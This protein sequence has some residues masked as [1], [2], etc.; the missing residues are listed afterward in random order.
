MWES[1]ICP[2]PATFEFK[3]YSTINYTFVSKKEIKERSTLKWVEQFKMKSW[4]YLPE[5][6]KLTQKRTY[7]WAKITKL[8]NVALKVVLHNPVM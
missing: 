3:Y 2:V 5:N 6:I 8:L 1:K 7:W 4:Y